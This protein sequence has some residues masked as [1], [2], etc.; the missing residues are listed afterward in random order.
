MKDGV[1]VA[2]EDF[3]FRVRCPEIVLDP[4]RRRA[5]R[6]RQ[7]E[8]EPH[9]TCAIGNKR[10]RERR[11]RTTRGDKGLLCI[12]RR[13]EM[14]TRTVN[15]LDERLDDGEGGGARVGADTYA[16]EPNASSG[17]GEHGAGGVGETVVLLD[18]DHADANV[19]IE[20]EAA[21]SLDLAEGEA[22][23]NRAEGDDEEGGGVAGGDGGSGSE[24]E[25]G[26]RVGG[27]LARPNAR[28]DISPR[29][30]R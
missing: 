21:E 27:S 17:G 10:P 14:G 19:A 3:F 2:D 13:R 25:Q 8:G 1:F 18:R 28:R 4:E 26:V 24:G 20:V 15:H 16:D 5:N 22:F 7:V 12:A 23:G 30:A 11:L 9:V 29:E 6:E